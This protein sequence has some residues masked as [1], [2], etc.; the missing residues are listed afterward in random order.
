M[1]ARLPRTAVPIVALFFL[2]AAFLNCHIFFPCKPYT[3]KHR[4]VDSLRGAADT[5]KFYIRL[6]DYKGD[7][8]VAKVRYKTTRWWDDAGF[9]WHRGV[10][11]RFRVYPPKLDS[12]PK[13]LQ[14]I[15]SKPEEQF[16]LNNKL[17]IKIPNPV[18]DGDRNPWTGQLDEP[19]FYYRGRE[20]HRFERKC[21]TIFIDH[22]ES[23]NGLVG[24]SAE[25]A[26]VTTDDHHRLIWV[27]GFTWGYDKVDEKVTRKGF[28]P[29]RGPGTDIRRLLDSLNIPKTKK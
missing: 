26:L 29:T 15:N 2:S 18:V 3:T 13:W 4:M 22:P 5:T 8:L 7:T 1:H 21:K 28:V 12:P 23:P 16:Q 10:K 14:V 19:P 20:H 6:Y 17:W 24:W 9:I 25:A 11:L 27:A